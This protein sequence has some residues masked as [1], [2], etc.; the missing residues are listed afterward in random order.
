MVLE[1]DAVLPDDIKPLLDALASELSGAEV[2]LLHYRAQTVCPITEVGGTTL[3]N[4][5]RLL[6]PVSPEPLAATTAYVMTSEAAARMTEFLDPVVYWPDD[7]KEYLRHGAIDRLRCVVPRPI[8]AEAGFKSTVGYS[9]G[10]LAA[11]IPSRLRAWRRERLQRQF[12][13][14]PLVAEA[15]QGPGGP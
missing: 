6:Y 10:L 7:W 13:Q 8:E 2:A 12:S 1:D 11:V 15:P 9:D 3:A 4:G 14:F 5:S